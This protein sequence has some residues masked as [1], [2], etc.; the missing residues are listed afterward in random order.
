MKMQIKFQRNKLDLIVPLLNSLLDLDLFLLTGIFYLSVKKNTHQ[1]I[2]CIVSALR[3]TGPC[4]PWF[5]PA[6]C[7][8]AA[9]ESGSGPTGGDSPPPGFLL[10][11]ST[12]N[13]HTH[14]LKFKTEA[15]TVGSTTNVIHQKGIK[16]PQHSWFKKLSN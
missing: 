13:T 9:S 3:G 4:S 5:A 12:T 6:V 14:T 15:S 2:T 8:S 11:G 16:H 1:G 10:P 7:G